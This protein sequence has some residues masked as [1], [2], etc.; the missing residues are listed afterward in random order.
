MLFTTTAQLFNW[1][2]DIYLCSKC[3]VIPLFLCPY[4]RIP[5]KNNQMINYWM[6]NKYK[7]CAHSRTTNLCLKHA[8]IKNP[9][10]QTNS[11][12]PEEIRTGTTEIEKDY[13]LTRKCNFAYDRYTF[14][15]M[16]SLNIFQ[17]CTTID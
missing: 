16:I 9:V 2:S 12:I 3:G 11:T 4:F 8:P 15:T 7:Q 14:F 10:T 5:L 13:F 17:I 1:F 6:C